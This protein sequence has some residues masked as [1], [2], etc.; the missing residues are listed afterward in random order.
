ML[1]CTVF[2]I[3]PLQVK[4]Y[5]LKPWHYPFWIGLDHLK[6]KM[7]PNCSTFSQSSANPGA[8]VTATAVDVHHKTLPFLYCCTAWERLSLHS[9][10]KL[11]GISSCSEK[12]LQGQ[13]TLKIS[14]AWRETKPL[15]YEATDGFT[16]NLGFV[17]SSGEMSYSV[18]T[19]K[20]D[21]R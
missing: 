8:K 10:V 9:P 4:M 16:V 17:P 1:H 19:R 13:P 2:P 7:S 6:A 12:P 20:K 18:S 5:K 11:H 14:R 21:T 15:K 3:M